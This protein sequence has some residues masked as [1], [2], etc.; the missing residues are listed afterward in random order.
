MLPHISLETMAKLAQDIENQEKI[1]FLQQQYFSPIYSREW[2]KTQVVRKTLALLNLFWYGCAEI[3][4]IPLFLILAFCL[5][6][7]AICVYFLPPFHRF[8]VRR[9]PENPFIRMDF[10]QREITFWQNQKCVKIIE[11]GLPSSLMN[12]Q[13]PLFLSQDNKLILLNVYDKNGK[14][15][16][17][18]E[19]ETAT[20][21]GKSDP[22]LLKQIDDLFGN[23]A[24]KMGLKIFFDKT[25]I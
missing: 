12:E 25:G 21:F 23:L 24:K 20:L 10:A 2:Y 8:F 3:W 9:L 14:A 18:L 6:V 22:I 17:I 13:R 11:L 4:L 7:L 15:H 5:I 16:L 1:E 19:M